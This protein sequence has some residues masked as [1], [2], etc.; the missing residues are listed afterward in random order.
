[1]TDD[2]YRELTTE[3]ME[4]ALGQKDKHTK[5]EQIAYRLLPWSIRQHVERNPAI[6][7]KDCNVAFFPDLLFRNERICIEID[8]GY[9]FKRLRQDDYRD[10]VF[11]SHGFIVIRIKNF[12]MRVDV[13]FWQRLLEGLEK[14]CCDRTAI[15]PFL[16]E[17]HQMVDDKI[18]S[19]TMIG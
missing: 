19:W 2:M 13:V 10:T 7:F 1:M 14:D 15:R 17:L 9:H 18:R 12:D 16:S 5:S 8:G 6:V 3:E 11:K 4:Q